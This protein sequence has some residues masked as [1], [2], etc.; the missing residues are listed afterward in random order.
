M[1][2][3]FFDERLEEAILYAKSRILTAVVSGTEYN[4]VFPPGRTPKNVQRNKT[5]CLVRKCSS[6]EGSCMVE[7]VSADSPEME[8]KKW[9]CM[10]PLLFKNATGFFLENLFY[11]GNGRPLYKF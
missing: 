1:E 6:A 8:K 11:S 5:P 3:Y 2:K 10:D 7:A 4:A 9:I